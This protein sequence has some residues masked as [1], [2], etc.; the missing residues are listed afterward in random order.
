MSE[1]PSVDV[2]LG[3][4]RDA[5]RRLASVLASL[6]DAAVREPSLLPGWT[7]GHVLTHIARNADGLANL[8]TWARTGVETPMYAS[9]EARNAD[10]EA[11]AGRGVDEQRQDVEQAAARFFAAVEALEPG[12]WNASVKT[13]TSPLLP[14]SQV[15]WMRAREMWVHVV[16]VDAGVGPADWPDD[17]ARTLFADAAATMSERVAEPVALRIAGADGPPVALGPAGG[18]MPLEVEGAVPSLTAWL[19][20]RSPGRDLHVNGGGT[21][22]RLPAWI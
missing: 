17:V 22:P 9:R 11:G 12:Q 10:I 8:L 14:A 13:L 1:L 6:D 5:D 20:G 3:W 16:D 19:I 21:A 18:G 2:L 4:V 15:P 7:R